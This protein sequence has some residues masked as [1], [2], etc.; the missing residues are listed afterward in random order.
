MPLAPR[1]ASTVTSSRGRL[2]HSTSLTGIEDEATTV[3]PFGTSA[4]KERAMA[5][6]VNPA[7]AASPASIAPWARRSASDHCCAHEVVARPGE[8]ACTLSAAAR[9]SSSGL[10]T[11][12]SPGGRSGA[13]QVP[14]GPTSTWVQSRPASHSLTTRDAHGAPNRRTKSGR[15]RRTTAVRRRASADPTAPGTRQPLCGVARTG[16]PVACAR[17]HTASGGP[18]PTPA[19]IRP[20]SPAE[21]TSSTASSG[22]GT[23]PAERKRCQ[24]AP[25]V[26]PD[27]S[28]RERAAPVSAACRPQ[29]R[30]YG[31]IHVRRPIRGRRKHAGCGTEQGFPEG[32]VEVDRPRP[33]RS[34]PGFQY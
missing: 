27:R 25:P 6:S 29:G 12:T 14:A 13:A 8:L 28:N 21:A 18:A 4:S 10:V 24:G 33:A 20:R 2:H 7:S 16:H 22:G 26:L 30:L 17:R 9:Q 1:L 34:S 31:R 5:G 11:T 32:Q 19:T 3:V 23:V 15:H